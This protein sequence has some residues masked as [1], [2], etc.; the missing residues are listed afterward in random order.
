MSAPWENS[1]RYD[2]LYKC[3]GCGNVWKS[4]RVVPCSPHCRYEEHPEFNKEWRTKPYSRRLF[5]SWKDFRERFP[6]VTNLPKDLL[7]WEARDK[8]YQAKKRAGGDS[9]EQP[10]SKKA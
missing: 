5:L 7:D 3:E 2:E 6:H 9:S 8:A 4:T 10:Y 1:L